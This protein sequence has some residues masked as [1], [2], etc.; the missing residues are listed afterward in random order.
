LLMSAEEWG[1]WGLSGL[2]R[3]RPGVGDGFEDGSLFLEGSVL[4]EDFAESLAGSS[5]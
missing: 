5:R 1:P 3:V 2:V 4:V